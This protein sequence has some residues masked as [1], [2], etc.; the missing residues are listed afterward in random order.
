MLKLEVI[1]AVLCTHKSRSTD[2]ARVYLSVWKVF[3]EYMFQHVVLGPRRNTRIIRVGWLVKGFFP[4]TLV[5][6][7]FAWVFVTSD[8]RRG[9]N[10]FSQVFLRLVLV[11]WI[12][13]SVAFVPS[14]EYRLDSV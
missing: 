8:R 4:S 12:E 9:S 14:T 3:V 10:M 5:V 7:F 6:R 11:V 1:L 13:F 2:R